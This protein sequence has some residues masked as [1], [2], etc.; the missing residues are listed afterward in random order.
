MFFCGNAPGRYNG[1][2]ERENIF[3]VVPPLC[4]DTHTYPHIS[5]AFVQ[6]HT[7]NFIE[8][9]EKRIFLFLQPPS[10]SSAGFYQA[11]NERNEMRL[12]YL[13]SNAM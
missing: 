11:K 13:H 4:C 2:R 7:L 3:L 10:H 6:L 1:E 9:N 5:S 8:I 12:V